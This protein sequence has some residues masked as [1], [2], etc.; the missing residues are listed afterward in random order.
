MERRSSFSAASGTSPVGRQ[1]SGNLRSHPIMTSPNGDLKEEAMDLARSPFSGG[2]TFE[3]KLAPIRPPSK[4]RTDAWAQTGEQGSKIATITH[5]AAAARLADVRAF[6]HKMRELDVA[7]PPCPISWENVMY[8]VTVDPE[9]EVPTVVSALGTVL[10]PTR[11]V[12]KKLLHGVSGFADPGSMVLVLGPPGA[13]KTL[14]INLLTQRLQQA[15]VGDTWGKILYRGAEAGP[16]LNRLVAFVDSNDLHQPVL[17]VR[18]TFDFASY[19]MVPKA[20]AAAPVNKVVLSAESEDVLSGTRADVALRLLGLTH[21]SE[22]WVGDDY[23]RGVSSGEKRRVSIGEMGAS[24]APVLCLD[25]PNNG[26]D[27]VVA[28]NLTKM[29]RVFADEL[30]FSVVATMKQASDDIYNEFDTVCILHE[31][32]LAYFGPS[33]L[34]LNYFGSLGFVKP[35]RMSVG[36]FVENVMVPNGQQLLAPNATRV[37]TGGEVFAATFSQSNLAKMLNTKLQQSVP[38]SSAHPMGST[39]AVGFV[40]QFWACLWRQFLANTRKPSILVQRLMNYVLVG[41]VSGTMWWQVDYSFLGFITRAGYLFYIITYVVNTSYVQMS[42]FFIQRELFY[43]QRRAKLF[44]SP[45]FFLALT[46]EDILWTIITTIV[47]CCITYWFGGFNQR[48]GN[49]FFY[50]FMFLAC[51]LQ[52]SGMHRMLGAIGPTLAVMTL[53]F[54][55]F[56]VTKDAIPNGWKWF[57]WINPMRY[58]IEGWFINEFKGEVFEPPPILAPP[59]VFPVPRVVPAEAYLQNL[60]DIR[61]VERWRMWVDLLAV[62]LFYFFFTAVSTIWLCLPWG[63]YDFN[64]RTRPA[65]QVEKLEPVNAAKEETNP[66]PP[67]FVQQYF[68]P[69]YF[70]FSDVCYSIET[71]T[72]EALGSKTKR[73]RLLISGVTGYAVPGTVTAVM[74][75]SG[76]G[77]TTLLD[78]L[79]GVKNQGTSEGEILINGAPRAPN[80]REQ[81]GYVEKSDVHLK[82]STVREALV[83]AATLRLPGAVS[84]PEKLEMVEVAIALMGLGPVENHIIGVPGESGLAADARKRLTIAVEL[85]SNPS[86]LFMDEPT[87]GFDAIGALTVMKAIRT[88]AD[89]GNRTVLAVVHQPSAELFSLFDSVLLLNNL[90]QMIYFGPT[91]QDASAVLGYLAGAVGYSCP[92]EKNPAEYLLEVASGGDRAT[93]VELAE[94]YRHSPLMKETRHLVGK[95]ESET[96]PR[97]ANSIPLVP[98]DVP[99]LKTNFTTSFATQTGALIK[100]HSLAMWRDP[101]YQYSRLAANAVQGFVMGTLFFRLPLNQNGTIGR[102]GFFFN[103]AAM[104][105][106]TELLAMNPIIDTRVLYFKEHRSRT[107]GLWAFNIATLVT[108]LPWFFVQHCCFFFMYYYIGGLNPL[109]G[110]MWTQFGIQGVFSWMLILIGQIV[111]IVAQ[112][113]VEAAVIGPPAGAL[114]ALTGG[115]LI[116]YRAMPR[117]WRSWLYWI[118]PTHYFMEAASSNEL[119]GLSFSCADNTDWPTRC[120]PLL[121]EFATGDQV[122]GFFSWSW[123]HLG[124][125]IAILAS[126]A[127]FMMFVVKPLALHFS[128]PVLR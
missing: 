97:T 79:A 73:K 115:F 48:A 7:P 117:F 1:N 101:Y 89:T 90:G 24:G 71:A 50:M 64:W 17:T 68:V 42:Q 72:K 60:Y 10:T 114:L 102:C 127:T 40:A 53:F 74:G 93:Q 99:Q 4:P 6:A 67:A 52:S 125:S 95:S 36:D 38:R 32:Y 104:Q 23:Y 51:D 2:E 5:A 106:A 69:A 13:G 84:M 107:Y 3:V 85:M 59:G 35:P 92:M 87:S 43:K 45:A 37:P 116:T 41:I 100:R 120:N 98:A 19:L 122:L 33:N 78:I 94:S 55:G 12:Y 29:L 82:Q 34:V 62:Y 20:N 65:V 58:V 109:P 54:A 88:L 63:L 96:G 30:N 57:Y 91:G 113:K 110:R 9:Q 128:R 103:L 112:D 44:S 126:F 124:R 77:K 121:N 49:F 27:S 11:K 118:S 61:G 46:V 105:V 8:S 56:V 108:E 123:D 21:V 15:G 18:E 83:F 28:L 22:T 119:H 66:A 111:G 14:L 70:S 80:F 75:P 47:F 25:E 39:Y 16:D 26:L 86:L 76:A 31:G 81:T